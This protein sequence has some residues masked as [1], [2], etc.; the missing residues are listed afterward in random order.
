MLVNSRSARPKCCEVRVTDSTIYL[1]ISVRGK[2]SA[3]RNWI[4]NASRFSQNSRR[5]FDVGSC[6]RSLKHLAV[7]S[8][9]HADFSIRQISVTNASLPHAEPV[10]AVAGPDVSWVTCRVTD[11]LLWSTSDWICCKS[12]DLN[13]AS[14]TQCVSTLSSERSV[15][16]YWISNNE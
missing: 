7:A 16:T 15:L 1:A 2:L 13:V 14:D 4:R 8:E 11:L 10:Q 12:V 5:Q 9:P 3:I 6:Y